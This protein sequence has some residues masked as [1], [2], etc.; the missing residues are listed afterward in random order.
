MALIL[1]TASA[2]SPALSQIKSGDDTAPLIVAPEAPELDRRQVELVRYLLSMIRE[3]DTAAILRARVFEAFY[4]AD[5]DGEPGITADDTAIF[6]ARERAERRARLGA[7]MLGD[8]IDGDGA[9]TLDELRIAG[10]LAGMRDG[11]GA[12]RPAAPVQSAAQVEM[13]AE[14]YALKRLIENDFDHDGR[15]TI[16]DAD[17]QIAAEPR[18]ERSNFSPPPD[19]FDANADGRITEREMQTEFDRWIAWLD[20]DGN[21]VISGEE[22][23][24][25]E[26]V[27][28]RSEA[29]I[30][31]RTGSD[32]NRCVL[33]QI[34]PADDVVVIHG[35][36]G[37]G[38]VDLTYGGPFDQPVFMGEV[39]VPAGDRPLWIIAS[40]GQRM[41]LR[42]DGA[43][44]RVAGLISIAATTGMTGHPKQA[45]AV[46]TRC[47][48]GFLGIRTVEP[49][50]TGSEALTASFVR[51]LRRDDVAVFEIDTIGR[52]DLATGRNDPTI[53]LAGDD[54]PE[55]TGDARF[56]R[57]A[58]FLFSPGG[59]H[60]L[61]PGD[62]AAPGRVRA[63]D[64]P[65]LPLE[66]GLLQLIDLGLVEPIATPR[67]G[68]VRRVPP[69]A[70]PPARTAQDRATGSPLIGGL[71]Y[72]QTGDGGWIGRE[73]LSYYAPV[74]PRIPPGLDGTRGIRL[75]VA[76]ATDKTLLDSTAPGCRA[77]GLFDSGPPSD[78]AC[79]R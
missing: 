70:K 75:I 39:V 51:A 42:L 69:G 59:F 33:P 25:R 17:I 68:L 44:D 56:T 54:T 72:H 20:A 28:R 47:H 1:I 67:S 78:D 14:A 40:F 60:D 19:A 35:K 52:F 41:L 49:G 62:V 15:L 71:L 38:F 3:S 4:I 50:Q 9:V 8:D 73:P 11:I 55:A 36:T 64:R 2:G 63:A 46:E 79:L 26:T 24:E 31:R 48:V 43:T 30:N 58:L 10:R 6:A 61:D 34:P 7:A 53:R 5:V 23:R 45:L 77:P 27:A 16:A 13:L 29:L 22:L 37:S 18:P 66:A 12:G 76:K 32:A 57:E 65:L 74:Q 21:G